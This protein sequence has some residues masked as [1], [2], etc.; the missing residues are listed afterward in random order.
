MAAEELTLSAGW[1]SFDHRSSLLLSSL[2]LLVLYL[3]GSIIYDIYHGP[4]S[5]FP[6]PKLSA[7]SI[8]PYIRTIVNGNDNTD[9]PA[10]HAKYGPVV[11]ISPR[12]L[13]YAN[14]A[15]AFREIYGS[16]SLKRG[17]RK[18]VQFYG[19]PVN[20][21]HSLVTADDAE[22]RRQRK[23]LSYGFSDRMVKDQEALLKRWAALLEAKMRESAA[24]GAKTDVAKFYNCAT[25]GRF[26]LTVGSVRTM[27][28]VWMVTLHRYHERLDFR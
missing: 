5:K 9:I 4:L 26:R 14:G 2:A 10:L 6:G 1:S 17:L 15:E 22:H 23:V 24:D 21:V 7:A 16:G 3:S 25:F 28:R 13:S 27:C 8:W 12:H 20:G 19:K 11:R 18:D